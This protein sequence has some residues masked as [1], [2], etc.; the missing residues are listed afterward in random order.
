MA[1]A[2]PGRY[3]VVDASLPLDEVQKQIAA[4]L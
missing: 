1:K 4:V 2:S 3:R